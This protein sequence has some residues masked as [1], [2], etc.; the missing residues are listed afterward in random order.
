LAE[1]AEGIAAGVD[2]SGHKTFQ[3]QRLIRQAL[4]EAGLA[5]GIDADVLELLEQ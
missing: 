5:E 3:A 1:E 2:I 4:V